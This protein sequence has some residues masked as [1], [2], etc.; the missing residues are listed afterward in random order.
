MNLEDSLSGLFY[1]GHSLNRAERTPEAVAVSGICRERRESLKTLPDFPETNLP[2]SST[3]VLDRAVGTPRKPPQ[4]VDLLDYLE[5]I[6]KPLKKREQSLL[7]PFFTRCGRWAIIA[8]DE[9]LNRI[10]KRLFCGKQW[11]EVCRDIIHRRK[12]ARCLPRVQQFETMGYWVIR[13]PW[14]LMPLLRTKKRRSRFVKKVKDAFRAI[15]YKRGL[16]FIH[17]F[18]E[19]S[20]KYAFHLNVL[21][22][23]RYIPDEQLDELKRKLRRMIYPRSVIRKWGDKL[24]INYH[25][26]KSPAEIMHA[27]KYCTKATFTDIEWDEELASNLHGAHY[28]SWWGKWDESL[29]WQLDVS[30]KELQSLS[31]IE[32]GKHPVSGKPIRWDKRPVPFASVEKDIIADLGGGYYLLRPIRPPPAKRRQDTNLIE[33][34]DGDYRKQT[35][36]VK[37]HGERADNILSMLGDGESYS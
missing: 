14:E 27:L 15:E 32:Q 7:P 12:I 4:K 16:T 2:P 21:V 30:D 23:G 28:S 25:Y 24:D 33:L 34:P 29:K 9:E 35:N 10:S 31:M 11:C 17:D 37:R 26:R 36:L 8:I 3:A 18:G 20:I 5:H 19:R 1:C 22:D 6:D 13:P